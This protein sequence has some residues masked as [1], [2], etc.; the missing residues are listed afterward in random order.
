MK[1]MHPI[2]SNYSLLPRLPKEVG[3]R[4]RSLSFYQS[5]QW[6]YRTPKGFIDW[7]DLLAEIIYEGTVGYKRSLDNFDATS[8]LVCKQAVT[9]DSPLRCL[10]SEL[11]QAFLATKLCSIDPDC[12]ALSHFIIALPEGALKD[13]LGANVFA[14]L[15]STW[16]AIVLNARKMGIN[17][18]FPPENSGINGLVLVGLS[19]AGSHLVDI[20]SF[21]DVGAPPSA[22]EIDEAL[23]PSVDEAELQDAVLRLRLIAINS[24][25]SMAFKPE[26]LSTEKV[27]P[28]SIGKGFA[29]AS[30]VQRPRA[31][32]WIGKDFSRSV[33]SVNSSEKRD[34]ASKAPHWRSGHWHT[35]RHGPGKEQARL[36]WFQPVYVNAHSSV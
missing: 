27:L 9:E 16:D 33:R 14:V 31:T 32:T 15:V 8:A 35:V 25:L 24:L 11:A 26:L 28:V 22:L 21:K 20:I 13:D 4:V 6:L 7:R 1:K 5:K 3:M 23:Q 2:P 34:G 19:G 36:A 12:I 29:K 17:M 30:S 10:S 18:Q